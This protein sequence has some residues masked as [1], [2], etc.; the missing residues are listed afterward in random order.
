M[1]LFCQNIQ[2][3]G[4]TYLKRA[5]ALQIGPTWF[6]EGLPT[7]FK[8]GL[9][10]PKRV[11]NVLQRGPMSLKLLKTAYVLQREPTY[12]LQRGPTHFKEGLPM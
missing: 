8:E 10:A 7:Y 9:R 2:N 6:R 1:R 3:K 4:P 12:V 11:L 5:Y